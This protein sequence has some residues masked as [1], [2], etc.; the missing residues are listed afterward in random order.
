[1]LRLCIVMMLTGIPVADAA[2][3][4]TPLNDTMAAYDAT[5]WQKS[6]GWNNGAPFQVGWRADHLSFAG[7][8][9]TLTLD[10]Q[11]ACSTTSAACSLQPFASGEYKSIK[12]ISYGRLTF[13][14]RAASGSGVI[15]G[16][17][18]Y[19]GPTDGQPHDE[20]DIEILGKNTGQVQFNYF[21]SGVGGHEKTVSL[22]FDAAAALHDYTIEWLPSA[23][24]WYV[25]GILKYTVYAAT[26]VALPSF[27]QHIFMNL[28]AATGVNAWSGLFTYGGTPVTAQLDMVTYTPAVGAAAATTAT[29]GGCVIASSND[30]NHADAT[31]WLVLLL[32]AM[33]VVIR[34]KR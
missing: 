12:M 6:D 31:L 32:L 8:L 29:G 19:T 11:P 17:F 23:I 5:V 4:T 1:M 25:D 16:L 14:A 22:G 2:T 13:R 18:S 10:N 9:L 24:N 26:G 7:S 30:W 34:A 15:T 20:I 33:R 28:W 27:P 21:V 3:L